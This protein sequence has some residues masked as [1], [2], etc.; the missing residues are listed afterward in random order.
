MGSSLTIANYVYKFLVLAYPV[1]FRRRFGSE[2]E[3]AFEENCADAYRT[4]A[5]AL[6][7]L[8]CATAYDLLVTVGAEHIARFVACLRSDLK[9]VSK[10][11]VLAAAFGALAGNLF[12]VQNAVLGS[13]VGLRRTIQERLILLAI[14]SANIV[15]LWVVSQLLCALDRN[16]TSRTVIRNRIFA[17]RRAAGISMI[18]AVCPTIGLMI[19][20]HRFSAGLSAT[21]VP[22]ARYWIGTPIILLM[23]IL[24]VFFLQP[25]LT[26]R[27]SELKRSATS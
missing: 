23:T 24:I 14:A 9:L 11:P 26:P 15:V 18:L 21:A 4:G 5:I 17:F 12:F 27:N 7:T 25:L 6:V 10:S 2:M 3:C 1:E 13:F 22:A 8:C 19:S 20:T 16:A